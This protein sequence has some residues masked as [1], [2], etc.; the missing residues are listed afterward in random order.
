ML[1]QRC[2][3]NRILIGLV[4]PLSSHPN[5]RELYVFFSHSNNQSLAKI[6]K[7]TLHYFSILSPLT[8]KNILKTYLRNLEY[9]RCCEELKNVLYPDIREKGLIPDKFSLL[10]KDQNLCSLFCSQ[11][12]KRLI[13][14]IIIL[15]KMNNDHNDLEVGLIQ[16]SGIKGSLEQKLTIFLFV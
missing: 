13:H 3:K 1:V 12:I 10:L 14:D 4:K 9:Y 16:K 6:C 11:Y 15:D 7:E 8:G 2:R 5:N